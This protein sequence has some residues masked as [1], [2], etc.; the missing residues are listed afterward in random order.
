MG[1]FRVNG[2]GVTDHFKKIKSLGMHI[3]PVCGKNAEF[4]LEEARQKIDIIFIPTVTLKSRYAVM[5]KRCGQGQF[6]SEQWA[7]QLI[8]SSA[9]PAVLFESDVQQALP[10]TPEP[11]PPAPETRP[12]PAAAS[13]QTSKPTRSA[14]NQLRFFRCPQCG[15]T[16]IREGNFCS[17]CGYR[18]D[19]VPEE[20]NASSQSGGKNNPPPASPAPDV[21]P[22]CGSH[23]KK[24]NKFCTNCGQPLGQACSARRICPGCGAEVADGMSFCTECG[25]KL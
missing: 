23:L 15:V 11:A 13:A 2:C 6:C 16:Q 14:S 3:C 22:S 24:E 21:C 20:P 18:I 1:G 8:N 12:E 25:R 10:P 7:V 19:P 9:P 17:Y 4:F 5:C